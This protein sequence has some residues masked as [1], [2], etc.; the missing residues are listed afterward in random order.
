[1]IYLLPPQTLAEDSVKNPVI[2]KSRDNLGLIQTLNANGVFTT[3]LDTAKAVELDSNL[4]SCT[5]EEKNTI[6]EQKLFSDVLNARGVTREMK[7]DADSLAR[8]CEGLKLVLREC[9]EQAPKERNMMMLSK[10]LATACEWVQR[11][12]FDVRG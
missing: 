8:V 3:D 7:I 6:I 11:E 2:S 10:K 9:E 5:T 12:S 4:D 1:M